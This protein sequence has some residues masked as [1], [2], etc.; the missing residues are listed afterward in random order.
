MSNHSPLSL[1]DKPFLAQVWSLAHPYWRSDEKRIAWLLLGLVVGLNY[2]IV[3]VA[4]LYSNWNRDFFNLMQNEEWNNFWNMLGQFVLIMA[5]YTVVDLA[6][7]YLRRTLRIRWRRWLTHAFLQ[8]WLGG[9]RLYRHQLT[10]PDSDNPDQRISQDVKDF[11]DNTLK[12]GLGLL[13]TVTSLFSFVVILWNLSG[14]FTFEFAGSEWVLPG[15]MV[16][17][18][19]IYSIVG[20]WLTHKIAKR[21]V[22]LNFEQEKSEADF[23]FHLMRVREH[24]ESIALQR[25]ELAENHRTQN[26][27]SKVWDNWQQLT[28]MKL[29]YG[30][31]TSGYN[32]V[33]RIFPYL[34]A[35][36]RLMSGALQLGD[37]MQTATGFYRVQE[38]FSWFVDSYEEVADWRAVTDRLIT[39][40]TQLEMLPT[41]NALP[42][43]K[44]PEWRD[45]NLFSPNQQTL[46]SEQSGSIHQS[47][48]IKGVSGGGKSTFIRSLA[49]LWPYQ[50]GD[51]SMPDD[52][53]CMFIPQ[54]PYLPNATL[55]EILLYP[56]GGLVSD[57]VLIDALNQAGIAKF[58]EQMDRQSNWQ[59]SVSGGE[60]QKIMLA[61][62]LVQK[63]QWLF[64]D[65]AMSALDPE[66][67]RSIRAVMA[68]QLPETHVVE[69]SHREGGA[70]EQNQITLC[71]Q[72][73]SFKYS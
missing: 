44:Q 69:V 41:T 29:K 1:K 40:H 42:L 2:L 8:K 13:R 26:L 43:S 73:Q 68:E 46:L 19:I 33:A 51:I 25:G 64:L 57:D 39:F 62:S 45:L 31:F 59:Q 54:K 36:P 34:V 24:A 23:R 47:I 16:W 50:S 58:A 71:T 35:S 30:A 28:G 3:E 38:A 22:P 49:G 65:E 17:V 53:A 52:S 12:M 10:Y 67:Y 55:R 56:S 9:K 48:T 61:R 20:T 72:T 18:A 6:E 11:C 70:E 66:S 63:P 15:Y 27:F 5:V 37:M 60:L 4:V 7:E 32:E 21:L 14:S